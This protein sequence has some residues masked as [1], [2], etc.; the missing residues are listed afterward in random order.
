MVLTPPPVPLYSPS[1]ATPSPRPSA[2]QRAILAAATATFLEIGYD[3]ASMDRIAQRAGVSKITIY[4]HFASKEALF[5]EIALRKCDHILEPLHRLGEN[6]SSLK[7]CLLS[8]AQQMLTTFLDAEAMGLYRLIIAEVKKFP[9]LGRALFASGPKKAVDALAQWLEHQN[10]LGLLRVPHPQRAA[11]LFFG[12]VGG[13]FDTQCLLMPDTPIDQKDL[14]AHAED[15][16]AVF[17]RYF[18]AEGAP[19][20]P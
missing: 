13:A 4:K 10:H 5:S 19:I 3:A 16:V 2:K 14:Q 1:C 17:L 7:D 8:V 18:E 20:T 15:A 9:D 11:S 6:G 12:M